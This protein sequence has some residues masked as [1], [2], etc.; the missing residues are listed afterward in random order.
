VGDK[1]MQRLTKNVSGFS[2]F[3]AEI[4]DSCCFNKDLKDFCQAYMLLNGSCGRYS[5]DLPNL[6]QQEIHHET[7]AHYQIHTAWF[8][9]D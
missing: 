1:N 5:A 4:A 3:T 8:Y 9:P 6:A 7:H 2:H